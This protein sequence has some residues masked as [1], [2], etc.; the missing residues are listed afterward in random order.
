MKYIIPKII[1][2]LSNSCDS[3]NVCT[4]LDTLK[5]NERMIYLLTCIKMLKEHAKQ[6]PHSH[7]E[8]YIFLLIGKLNLLLKMCD[9]ISIF[10]WQTYKL[11]LCYV[12]CNCCKFDHINW[13][14]QIETVKAYIKVIVK[15]SICLFQCKLHTFYNVIHLEQI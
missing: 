4:G 5:Q 13:R 3:L 10:M 8:G 7:R 12:K 9:R 15:R 1:Q 6:V 2:M 14:K 11:N